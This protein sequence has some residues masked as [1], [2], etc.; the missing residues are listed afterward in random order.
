[1][2]TSYG[3]S[4]LKIRIN[5]RHAPNFSAI[6]PNFSI[7]MCGSTK[8]WSLQIWVM[9]TSWWS[10]LENHIDSKQ[11]PKFLCDW[12]Q[13]SPLTS[14]GWPKSIVEFYSRIGAVFPPQRAW[15]SNNSIKARLLW[16]PPW[17]RWW[18]QGDIIIASASASSMELHPLGNLTFQK[19]AKT[20]SSCGWTSCCSGPTL[21]FYSTGPWKRAERLVGAVLL[22]YCVCVDSSLHIPKD[23]F[24]VLVSKWTGPAA[25]VTNEPVEVQDFREVT[26]HF[27]GT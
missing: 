26:E 4:P 25:K 27:R 18:C 13:T 8:I 5:S 2:W 1:M 15:R 24:F 12:N 9:A 16:K 3:S 21:I 20:C 6:E 23:I 10:P 19:S 11:F 22:D 14:A 17:R 7:H